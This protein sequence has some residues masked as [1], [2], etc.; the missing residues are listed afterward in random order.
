MT[1][2]IILNGKKISFTGNV[3]IKIKRDTQIDVEKKHDV[4]EKKSLVLEISGDIK[5][6]QC[7]NSIIIVNGNVKKIITLDGK[8]K[9]NNVN[10]NITCNS[11]N[12]NKVNGS[13]KNVNGVYINKFNG[14]VSTNKLLLKSKKI[15]DKSILKKGMTIYHSVN[16]KGKISSSYQ[17]FNNYI[18][19]LYEKESYTKLLSDNDIKNGKVSIFENKKIK[20]NYNKEIKK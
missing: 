9:C 18:Y 17:S 20:K 15:Y 11:I 4:K 19:V 2:E 16:G 10:G 8:I 3:V 14:S 12:V 7:D 5:N 1:N 6:L 13:I